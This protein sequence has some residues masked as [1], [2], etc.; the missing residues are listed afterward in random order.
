MLRK[1]EVQEEGSEEQRPI[2]QLHEHAARNLRF[3]RGT[4]EAAGP[5]T[6]VPGWGGV[7]MGAV[8]TSAAL[9]AGDP[10]SSVTDPSRWLGIWLAAAALAIGLGGFTAWR[11]CRSQGT[12]L[13]GHSG[14]RLLLG[15]APALVAGAVITAGLYRANTLEMAPSVWLLLYGAGVVSGGIYSVRSVPIM[16]ALFMLLGLVALWAPPSWGSF[17]LGMGFGGLHLAFGL[18]IARRHGG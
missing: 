18:W 14:R 1:V 6:A 17:F 11:K 9:F 13:T 8:G 2:I 4:M 5:F 3:I 10:P 12:S 7:A 16:G 15:L